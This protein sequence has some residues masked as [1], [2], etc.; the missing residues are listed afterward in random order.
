MT[1][2]LVKLLIKYNQMILA[3]LRVLKLY[4]WIKDPEKENPGPEKLDIK[5]VK[6]K[7]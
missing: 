2:V 7:R 6:D 4:F 1:V 3:K 5:L